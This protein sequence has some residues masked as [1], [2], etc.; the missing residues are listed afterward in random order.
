MP[1]DVAVA[2]CLA[3]AEKRIGAMEVLCEMLIGQLKGERR[4]IEELKAAIALPA[5]SREGRSQAE[6]GDISPEMLA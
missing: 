3:A 4:Q 2:H 1:K 5:P 6:A